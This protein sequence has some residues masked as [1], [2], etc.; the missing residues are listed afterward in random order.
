MFRVCID[1][2][3]TFTDSMVLNGDCGPDLQGRC[4][5][6]LHHLAWGL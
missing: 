2:G 1:T 4:L 6:Q 5:R 3:G